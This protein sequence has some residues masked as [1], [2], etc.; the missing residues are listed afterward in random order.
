MEIEVNFPDGSAVEL[1]GTTAKYW[2][3]CGLPDYEGPIEGL[4]PEVLAALLANKVVKKGKQ[5]KP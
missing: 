4:P 3:G 2:K 1:R 5:W